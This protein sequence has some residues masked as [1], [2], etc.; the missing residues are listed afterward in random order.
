MTMAA[1]APG[2]LACLIGR[3]RATARERQA[4]GHANAQ[5]FPLRTS[6]GLPAP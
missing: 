6:T 5:W 2:I 1:K 3:L 4:T